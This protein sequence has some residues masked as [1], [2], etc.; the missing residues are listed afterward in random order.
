MHIPYFGLI[1]IFVTWLCYEV[2]KNK[3]SEAK[4][5]KDFWE[6]ERE[7]T[8]V[9][10]KSTDDV[11]F[12]YIDDT[13]LPSECV[14]EESDLY[15]VCQR[16]RSYEG[17]KLANLSGYSNTDLKMMYGVANF[18]ELSEADT[19]FTQISPLFGR[20]ASLLYEEGRHAEAET[21]GEYAAKNGIHTSLVM[22]TLAKI[23]SDLGNTEKLEKLVE[24]ARADKQCTDA[25]IEKLERIN[26]SAHEA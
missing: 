4:N 3:R 15:D 23:Y 11:K 26:T 22:C 1:M 21:V 25:T 13:V 6:R 5:S 8:S 17:I 12:F 18:N 19:A 2:R 9:R 14:D 16:I 20:L 24:M 7:A 10:R